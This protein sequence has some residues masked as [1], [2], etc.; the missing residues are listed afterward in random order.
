MYEYRKNHYVGCVWWHSKGPKRGALKSCLGNPPPETRWLHPRSVSRKVKKHQRD[1][2]DDR[3]R[4]ARTHVT[5]G[6]LTGSANEPGNNGILS[7][8][9][10]R[11]RSG[12]TQAAFGASAAFERKI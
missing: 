2:L 6:D 1:G 3:K 12:R 10:C 9:D 5:F 8:L 4:F 11:K 7:G